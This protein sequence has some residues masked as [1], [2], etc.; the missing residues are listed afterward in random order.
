M[1]RTR[2]YPGLD[3]CLILRVSL[4]WY[5]G[6][7]CQDLVSVF[8]PGAMFPISIGG[9]AGCVVSDESKD[10][11]FQ[12]VGL[13]FVYVDLCFHCSAVGLWDHLLMHA[14]LTMALG[15]GSFGDCRA[16]SLTNFLMTFSKW[17]D[18]AIWVGPLQ[19]LELTGNGGRALHRSL[20]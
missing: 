16:N 4:T 11:I 15:I 7:N 17:T 18:S 10:L 13:N 2:S 9:S 6:W 5:S 20:P 3:N 1:L 12:V 14:A 8:C 19:L